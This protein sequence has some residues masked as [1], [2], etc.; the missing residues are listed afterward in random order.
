M[1]DLARLYRDTGRVDEAVTGFRRAVAVM[2][3]AWGRDDPDYREAAVE[4]EEL[5]DASD[6]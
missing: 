1:A 5:M 4:L 3:V 2:A 6:G